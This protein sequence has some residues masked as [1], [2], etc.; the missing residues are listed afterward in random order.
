MRTKLDRF[1]CMIEDQDMPEEP[2]V[3]DETSVSSAAVTTSKES[4]PCFY[5]GAP[6]KDEKPLLDLTGVT[7]FSVTN[8]PRMLEEFLNKFRTR[9]EGYYKV[10]KEHIVSILTPLLLI[11]SQN[12]CMW[13]IKEFHYLRVSYRSMVNWQDSADLLRCNKSFHHQPRYDHVLIITEGRAF[14][15]QLLSLFQFQTDT[16]SHSLALVQVYGRPP[17]SIRRKDRDLGLYR[18]RV[19][20]SPFAIIALE[21]IVRGALLVKDP[22]TPGDYFVVDTVDGDMFLR[23]TTLSL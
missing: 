6:E 17:G 21:S 3:E 5:L 20:N 11:E 13:Q 10:Q 23:M 14:F 18:I 12:M 1:D 8:L 15:A 19:K 9:E 2:D 7:T 22:D 4:S 16:R